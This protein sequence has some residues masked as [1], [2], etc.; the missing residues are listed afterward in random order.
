[1]IDYLMQTGTMNAMQNGP[2]KYVPLAGGGSLY[3]S[4]NVGVGDGWRKDLTFWCQ[5]Y[6]NTNPASPKPLNGIFL[7][8]SLPAHDP[9]FGNLTACDIIADRDKALADDP[10]YLIFST[11]TAAQRAVY[12]IIPVVAGAHYPFQSR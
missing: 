10:T 9:V 6:D 3:N 5:V 4:A 2:G 1:M 12:S 8:A 11:Y 7:W